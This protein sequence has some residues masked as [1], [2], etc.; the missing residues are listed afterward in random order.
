MTGFAEWNMSK[1]FIGELQILAC[2]VFFGLTFVG[3]RKAMIDGMNAYTFNFARYFVSVFAFIGL[4]PIFYSIFECKSDHAR[5]IEEQR[6]RDHNGDKDAVWKSYVKDVAIWGSLISLV[7]FGG[8]TLQQVG[9]ENLSASKTG[10]IT[11]LQ[12]IV[13]PLI[14]WAV[15]GLGGNMTWSLF[16]AICVSLTGLYLLSGC[17]ESSCLD[18]D[19]EEGE[20]W[21]I[22]SMLCWSLHAIFSVIACRYVDS[23]TLTY[24]HFVEVTIMCFIVAICVDFSAFEYPFDEFVDNIWVVLAVGVFECIGFVL[25]GLG[26]MYVDCSKASLLLTS[27]TVF[28]A[29]FGYLLLGETLTGIETVGGVLVIVAVLIIY[30]DAL[31]KMLGYRFDYARKEAMDVSETKSLLSDTGESRF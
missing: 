24:V 2:G 19:L 27:V 8:A 16:I 14:E 18:G 29:I 25:V 21:V 5:E 6:M 26:Y 20:I 9:M 28:T 10:F 30:H 12:V 22:L 7:S 17:T 15:P 1:E 11:R 23:L 13:V 3:E 4:Q 31:L